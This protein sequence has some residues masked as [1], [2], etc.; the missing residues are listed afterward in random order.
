MTNSAKA[1]TAQQ[2]AFVNSVLGLQPK[3]AIFDCDGTLWEGDAGEGFMRWSMREGI[4]PA[5]V[6]ARMQA[7]HAQ[8]KAGAVTE[9]DMCAEMVTM[10]AGLKVEALE[11]AARQYFAS[12]I[13]PNIYPEMFE[14]VARLMDGGC[15][16][17]LVS[18][19]NEWVVREG[20]RHFGVSPE[21]VIA[22]CARITGAIVTGDILRVPTD[23]GKAEAIRTIILPGHPQARVDV[24]VGNSIHDAAMLGAADYAIAINPT[25]AL[26]QLASEAGWQQYRPAKP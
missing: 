13:R 5:E 18:S 2:Q 23:E 22:A 8:Y 17:W 7:R 24:A 4:V 26:E 12:L 11:A 14:V 20:A 15:A 1:L 19:T 9:H 6:I 21:R 16:V 10:Y 25:A 3:I